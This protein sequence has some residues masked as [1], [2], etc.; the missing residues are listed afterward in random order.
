MIP[1]FVSETHKFNESDKTIIYKDGSI[2]PYDNIDIKIEIYE[3]RVKEWFLDVAGNLLKLE[4]SPGMSP[5]D[6][7]SVMIALAF[8]EGIEKFRCGNEIN[9]SRFTFKKSAEKIFPNMSSETINRLYGETRCGLFHSGF[10]DGKIYLSREKNLPIYTEDKKIFINPLKFIERI[11]E[12]FNN[13]ITELKN[14][15][16]ENAREKFESLWDKL[17]KK[18]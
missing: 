15:Y 14:P 13:Y 11:T 17:W 10:P 3:A 18:S 5:G 6:Y 12:Y 4:T 7:A 1:L 16:N 2:K 8:I 9:S